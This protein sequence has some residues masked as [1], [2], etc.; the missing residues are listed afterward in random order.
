MI[1]KRIWFTLAAIIGVLVLLGVAAAFGD[2]D[3]SI[4][5]SADQ[6]L[7]NQPKPNNEQPA[8]SQSS[9]NHSILRVDINNREDQVVA[10][11]PSS[12]VAKIT[13]QKITLR[14]VTILVGIRSLRDVSC[15]GLNCPAPFSKILY[16]VKLKTMTP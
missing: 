1:S 9:L 3:E 8:L 10:G 6:I 13:L 4:T 12:Y 2:S 16:Q 14:N 15:F 11:Q 5:A 7:A